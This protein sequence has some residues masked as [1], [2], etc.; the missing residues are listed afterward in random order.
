MA[1]QLEC[2]V[3][4]EAREKLGLTAQQ[5]ADKANVALRQYQRFEC[6]ERSLSGSSFSIARNILEA[7]ELDVASF[8]K[9]DGV[10]GEPIVEYK[11]RLETEYASPCEV[12]RD[13]ICV[14]I[15]KLER[16]TKQ[17]AQDRVFAAGGVPQNNIAA[18]VSFVIAGKVTETSK[19][20]KEAKRY[21]EYGLLTILSEQEFFDALDGKY[22]PPDNS[23][24]E[25]HMETIGGDESSFLNTAV[26]LDHKRAA[27][28]ASKKII[29]TQG[30]PLDARS[31]VAMQDFM[32][33]YVTMNLSDMVRGQYEYIIKELKQGAELLLD[34]KRSTRYNEDGSGL[35]T[36]Y[37]RTLSSDHTKAIIHAER[38]LESI[39]D[40]RCPIKLRKRRNSTANEHRVDQ[41]EWMKKAAAEIQRKL[42]T[43]SNADFWSDRNPSWLLISSNKRG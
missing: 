9:A 42:D 25:K 19:I 2:D 1:V 28:L 27:F 12:F 34:M 33:R 14:F 13:K 22:I 29:G 10:A 39:D 35:C 31:S 11:E 24:N 5:V 16:C 17:E 18:F 4:R 36:G 26:L 7:L 40:A 3:L 43:V 15:G 8:G 41:S 20:Y 6:G 21:E 32:T 30:S 38:F 23:T 37:N